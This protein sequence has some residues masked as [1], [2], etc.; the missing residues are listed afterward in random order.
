ML[1]ARST[2]IF[3]AAILLL[4]ISLIDF[5]YAQNEITST[6]EILK[7]KIDVLDDLLVITV[8]STL[9]GL[10]LAG[11]SFLLQGSRNIEEND[12]SIHIRLAKKNFVKAFIMFLICTISV[13]VFDFLEILGDKPSI[14][15][16]ILDIIITYGFF[17]FGLAYLVKA[18]TRIYATYGT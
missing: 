7:N 1:Q 13:F 15:V 14:Y 10:S 6:N 17:G 8:P 3:F 12:K 9:T 4:V 5:V 16:L 11:A 2:P 18:A